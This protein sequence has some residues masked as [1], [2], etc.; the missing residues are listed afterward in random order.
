[1][2]PMI[3]ELKHNPELGLLDAE[4]ILYWRGVGQSRMGRE[5]ATA[6]GREP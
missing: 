5:D 2:P 6:T 3:D 4:F 1:M